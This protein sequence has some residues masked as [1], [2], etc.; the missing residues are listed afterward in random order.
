MIMAEAS[1][2]SLGQWGTLVVVVLG[3]IGMFITRIKD[4]KREDLAQE[5]QKEQRD[6]MRQI[7]QGQDL[8]NG[9]LSKVTELNESHYTAVMHISRAR[10]EEMLRALT[11][12]CKAQAVVVQQV[13]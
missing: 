2:T 7:K 9:K 3:A 10:H 11:G 12:S 6:V 13:N 5:I 4:S 8:Q 1:G